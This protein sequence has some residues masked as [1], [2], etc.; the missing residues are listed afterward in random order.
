EP[1]RLCLGRFAGGPAGGLCAGPDCLGGH[2][3]QSR[4]RGFFVTAL[5]ARV[6][7]PPDWARLRESMPPARKRP[8]TRP[9]AGFSA[10]ADDLAAAVRLRWRGELPLPRALCW[11]MILVG[12]VV[13]L[14]AML[15][16]LLLLARGAPDLLGAA[17]YFAPLPYNLLLTVS[18]W[19]SAERSG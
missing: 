16:A 15:T 17:V 14:A 9:A 12:S 4:W 8:M 13:N 1:L 3:L 10:A 19:R 5:A 2:D 6:N 11:D 18:V 7:P